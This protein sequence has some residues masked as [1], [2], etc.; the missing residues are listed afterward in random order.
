[1]KGA[2]GVTLGE[3]ND[4]VVKAD[5]GCEA[6]RFFCSILQS[7]NRY[8]KQLE[9]LVGR[10]VVFC[11]N[12]VDAREAGSIGMKMSWDDLC[13]DMCVASDYAGM[14]PISVKVTE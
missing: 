9:K 5:N 12:R 11:N 14:H 1:M 8:K 2:C 3:Y 10:A 6:C 4:L 13:L 7:S